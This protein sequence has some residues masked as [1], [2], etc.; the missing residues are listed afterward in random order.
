MMSCVVGARATDGFGGPG[1]D[2]YDFTIDGRRGQPWSAGPNAPFNGFPGGF[3]IFNPLT[4]SVWYQPTGGSTPRLQEYRPATNSWTS[5]PVDV[6]EDRDPTPA[7]DTRRNL[8]VSVGKVSNTSTTPYS[9]LLYDLARPSDKPIRIKTTGPNTIE[10]SRFPGFVYDPVNDQFVGW[11][12]GTGIFTLKAPADP[13]T[14]TWVWS[15]LQLDAGN[16]VVPTNVA[17]LRQAGIV[18]GTFGRFRY[19]PSQQGVIVVNAGDEPV[20]FFKLPNGGF[21]L[22]SVSISADPTIIS[23]GGSTTLT[24]STVNA[25]ACTASGAWSGAKPTAGTEG[26]GPLSGSNNFILTCDNGTGG[27]GSGS[28]TVGTAQAI[29][30]PSVDLNANPTNVDVGG[31]TTLDWTSNSASSC[32]ASGGWSG[33]K[34]ISGSQNIGSVTQPTSFVLTCQGTGGTGSDAVTV[35]VGGTAPTPPARPALALSSESGSVMPGRSLRLS[36]NSTGANSCI[37][38]NGWSGAKAVSGSQVVT[39]A[40][41]SSTYV[42]ACSGVGGSV[43]R[44]VTVLVTSASAPTQPTVA[45]ARKKGGGGA[46]TLS[47]LLMLLGVLAARH[48]SR[49]MRAQ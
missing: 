46:M 3:C 35:N 13:K 47:T 41:S 36:W 37:A 28:V 5:Y 33:A 49:R 38:S 26:R 21:K 2:F 22:P 1:V 25:T 23:A 9:I 17:G 40:G 27:V 15:Q 30:A 48:M 32:T 39:P 42:L 8:L 34:M 24:W 43:E 4:Q 16:K 11:S 12:G 45:P 29:P 19:V 18:I 7:I 10:N 6:N 31:P 20:F 44:N 14:G